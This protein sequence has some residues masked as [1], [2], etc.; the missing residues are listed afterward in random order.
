MYVLHV[1][2]HGL[3]TV[4]NVVKEKLLFLNRLV[5]EVLN[6]NPLLA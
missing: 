2:M 6:F 5:T 3:P 4:T 1:A